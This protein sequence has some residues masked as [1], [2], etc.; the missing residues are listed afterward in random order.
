[1]EKNREVK[2]RLITIGDEILIGQI[3]DTNSA[4]IASLLERSGIKV[5]SII[6][7]SD[8]KEHIESA[9]HYSIN[10]FDVTITTGGLGP[11]KDDIT[12]DV[13]CSLFDCSLVQHEESYQINK[14]LLESRGIEFNQ[15]NQS[16]SAIPSKANVMININGTAPGLCFEKGN[17]LLFN[18][19]GVPFEM[20]ELMRGEV[21]ATIR[22]HFELQNI[23]HK[24]AITYGIAESILAK[25]IESWE[26]NLTTGVKLAYLPSPK[27]VRLRLTYRSFDTNAQ[28]VV[29]GEFKKLEAIIGEHI[30]GY[31]DEISLERNIAASLNNQGA[32]L[33]IAES[34]TGG[35]LSS[36]FTALDGASKYFKGAVV[37]YSNEAKINILGVD[38]KIIDTYGAVS[39][40]CAE[41]MALGVKQNLN[42]DYSIATTGIAGPTGG[43]DDKPVGTVWIAVASKRGV[44]SK[45]F[46]F[47]LLRDVNIERFSFAALGLLK[48]AINLPLTSHIVK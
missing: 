27:G 18:L 13:L 22:S 43:S 44:E 39:K 34:C 26:E 11:T 1:M 9:L 36:L 46:V 31:G 21:M 16:Q 47:G 23:V 38:N 2:A 17:N 19:P 45:R 24:T 41:A 37:S 48:S 30:I 3:V 12:K 40:E 6:S 20:K 28:E 35:K 32:T 15:L 42:S 14:A 25:Q 7:I 4:F 8:T 29:D 10:N 5:D 33:S